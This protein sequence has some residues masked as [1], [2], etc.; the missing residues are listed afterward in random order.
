MNRPWTTEGASLHVLHEEFEKR[1]I[2][3]DKTE[4]EAVPPFAL[5]RS[6]I[7]ITMDAK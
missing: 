4:L 2:N 3:D 1:S 5:I 6:K 7:Y